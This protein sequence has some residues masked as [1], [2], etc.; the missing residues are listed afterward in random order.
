VRSSDWDHNRR[1]HRLLLAQV[2]PDAARVLEVGCGAGTLARR[3]AARACSVDA[4]DCSPAMIA[5]AAEA[6]PPNLTLHLADLR[7]ADLP[8]GYYDAVVSSAVL[9]HLPPSEVL[10][11]MA[12]WARPG[13]ALAAVALPRVD[14]PRE[15]GVELAAAVAH[16]SLGVAFAALRPLTGANLFRPEATHDTMP[17]SEPEL[18]VRE[19]RAEA[20]RLLPGALVRRL[21]FWRYVLVWRRPPAA[22]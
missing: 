3:L 16:H 2:P 10:P 18:T 19:I 15:L 8:D 6:A 4:V 21:L 13:D 11:R 12:R 7:T 5:A 22:A 17:V 14:L 9:H 1:Y 20:A